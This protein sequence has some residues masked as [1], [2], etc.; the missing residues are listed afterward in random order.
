MTEPQPS[1]TAEAREKI[2]GTAARLFAEQGYENTSISQVA[3]AAKVSKALIFWYFETKEQLYHTA[4]RKTLEPY[5][6]NVDDLGGLN[7]REQIERLIE[8]FAEFVRENVYSVRF[9]LSLVLQGERQP[10]EVIR[11]VSELYGVFRN[12]LA[13]IIESGQRRG[14]F[15][16]DC[17]P[18]LDAALIM[19]ALDGVLV[20]NF[21]S[22]E[23]VHEAQGLIA[24][25]KTSLLGRLLAASH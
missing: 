12:L 23:F 8:L 19:A 5:F 15:R 20:Q 16:S 13:D 7:E 10:D 6:I 17:S 14:V 11:R 24:H 22:A 25:L 4:L 9:F 2:L 18:Q 21:L 1:H 3:R